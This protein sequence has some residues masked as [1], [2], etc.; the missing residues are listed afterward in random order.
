MCATTRH[1][2][3]LQPMAE[4]SVQ[5]CFPSDAAG[6]RWIKADL[7]LHTAEDPLDTIA[8]DAEALLQQAARLGFSAIAI[9]LHKKVLVRE[10]LARLAAELGILLIPSVELRIDG[11][12]VVVWNISPEE[13]DTVRSF[14]D[15]RALRATRQS[16]LMVMAPH[17]FYVLGGSIG[18]RLAKEIDCFDAVEYCHFHTK[19]FNPNRPAVRIASERQLPLVATSDAHRLWAFGRFYS[20]IGIG[21]NDGPLTTDT[22]FQAIR[23][24]HVRLTSPPH[25]L[26]QLATAFAFLFVEHPV[27]CILNRRDRRANQ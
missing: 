6:L 4:S 15:L 24:G 9:T 16:S 25:S 3:F 23:S 27:R 1:R 18:H 5:K 7:H 22:L 26:W 12:D 17:P 13:A 19:W 10:S 8:Y 14:D 21:A 20:E 2:D 11:C